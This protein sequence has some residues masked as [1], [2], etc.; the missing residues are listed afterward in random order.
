[1]I[2]CYEEYNCLECPYKVCVYDMEND[3]K[4]V[5]FG[6]RLRKARLDRKITQKKLADILDIWPT[7]LS[8]WE[9][10]DA[11][12]PPEIRAKLYTMFPELADAES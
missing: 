11:S 8:Q 10:C 5:R 1:M 3:V 6:E 4:S 2:H 9:L 7:R 12:P